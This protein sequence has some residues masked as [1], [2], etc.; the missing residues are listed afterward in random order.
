MSVMHPAELLLKSL[1]VTE[2]REIEL[3]DIAFDQGAEIRYC[4][5]SGCEADILGFRNKAII[6]IDKRRG[7]T[8]K[9]FSIA[10]ELGHWHFHRGKKL[11]CRVE[12]YL[13]KHKQLAERQ[14]ND[15]AASLLLPNY[16]IKPRARDHKKLTFK[17]IEHFAT[18]FRTSLPATAIRLVEADIWPCMLINHTRRGRKWFTQAPMFHSRWFPKG[19]LDPESSAF[20]TVFGRSEGDEFPTL[21]GADAWFDRREAQHYEILEQSKRTYDEEVLVLLTIKDN[22]MIEEESGGT[23]W[24]RWR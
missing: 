8:R 24:R 6:S 10:H 22:R 7:D 11:Q 4:E 3:E 18:D 19:E 14:A 15:Y 9:R 20:E 5:L 12:E 1:G 16:L 13:P 2:P 21:I 23:N 17:V